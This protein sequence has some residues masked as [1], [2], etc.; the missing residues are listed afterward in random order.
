MRTPFSVVRDITP[1]AVPDIPLQCRDRNRS[2]HELV[3]LR[4]EIIAD[5]QPAVMFPAEDRA[6]GLCVRTTPFPRHKKREKSET[7]RTVVAA[8]SRAQGVITQGLG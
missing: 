5:N 4:I 7:G 3:T 8:A 6:T 1:A 2:G